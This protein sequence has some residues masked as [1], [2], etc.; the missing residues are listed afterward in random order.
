MESGKE[1]RSIKLSKARL[2]LGK[3]MMKLPALRGEI[4]LLASQHE[5]LEDLCEAYEE[6]CEMLH[7][8]RLSRQIDNN[9][10]QEYDR[11]CIDIESDV[12]N[13]CINLKYR[14]I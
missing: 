13:Y 2:G 4:Q 3:L 5:T 14:Q 7:T 8:I 10:L 1:W 6:A 12:I 11:I 9:L